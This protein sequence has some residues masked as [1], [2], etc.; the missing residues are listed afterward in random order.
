MWDRRLVGR[1]STV[2][3]FIKSLLSKIQSPKKSAVS[4]DSSKKKKKLKPKVFEGEILPLS[5]KADFLL[6]GKN[7]LLNGGIFRIVS[8]YFEV[9]KNLITFFSNPHLSVVYL[10]RKVRSASS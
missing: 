3:V 8:P 7:H 6:Q 1:Q 5:H 4:K 2:Y 9:I 10:P